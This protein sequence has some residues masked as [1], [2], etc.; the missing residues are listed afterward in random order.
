MTDSNSPNPIAVLNDAFRTSFHGGALVLTVGF[1][2]LPE[3]VQV[4]VL[5]AV[6]KFEAFTPDNDPYQEHDF[7]S[8]TYQGHRIF[9]KIDY[10]DP[11]LAFGS[12]DPAN[13]SQTKRVLTIML[14]DEY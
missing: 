8:F 4:E 7:G 1:Q 6:R 3:E 13:P 5:D 12:E 10:Y 11:S 14:A 2:A 9:W